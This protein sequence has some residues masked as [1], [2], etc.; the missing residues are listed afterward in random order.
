MTI[1]KQEFYEGAALY[2]LL[3]TNAVE[4]VSFANPFFILND[5]IAV[6]LKYSTSKDSP[7]NFVFTGNELAELRHLETAFTYHVGLV[8]GSDG[9]VSLQRSQV[10]DLVGDCDA[11]ARVGCY[12][13]HDQLYQVNGPTGPLRKKISRQSWVRILETARNNEAF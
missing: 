9:V 5:E 13:R 6:L 8:C 3:K 7:W 4:R 2:Q 10:L 1:K 12:R 11:N